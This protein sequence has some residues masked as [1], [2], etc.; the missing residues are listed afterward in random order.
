[1]QIAQKSPAHLTTHDR[2]KVLRGNGERVFDFE[3]AESPHACDESIANPIGS[4]TEL[5]SGS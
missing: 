2:R 4:S 5:S 1:M 3:P